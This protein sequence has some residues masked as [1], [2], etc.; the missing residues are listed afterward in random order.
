VI[1]QWQHWKILDTQRA[2]NTKKI[3]MIRILYSVQI[4]KKRERLFREIVKKPWQGGARQFVVQ[5]ALETTF[6]LGL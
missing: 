5:L 4:Q 1:L 6:I 3:A 2:W